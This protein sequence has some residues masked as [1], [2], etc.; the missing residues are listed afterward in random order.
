MKSSL[1]IALASTVALLGCETTITTATSQFHTN[2]PLV[3]ES[4]LS[5]DYWV[6]R[7]AT[8]DAVLKN[9]SE[10]DSF[11]QALIDANPHIEDVFALADT[12]GAE[13]L[14]NAIEE[15][16][17][18]PK[19]AR[20]YANGQQLTD[21]DWQQLEAS[22]NKTAVKQT[23]P[24]KLGL[25]VRRA[26]LRTYPTSTPVYKPDMD[27]DLDRFQET[28]LYP[29]DAVALLHISVDGQWGFV[30]AFHYRAWVPLADIALG[31][32]EKIK[33]F[34]FPAQSLVVTGAQ[35]ETNFVPDT[36]EVSQIT[37]DMGVTLP[38]V[39]KPEPVLYG[40]NTTYSRMVQLPTRAADGSLVIRKALIA[41]SQDTHVGY[42]PF[43]QRNLIT[44]AFKFLGERYGWG[45]GYNARDCTGFVSAIYRSMGM[46]MP[47]NSSQQGSSD[48]GQNWHY[49]RSTPP[50]DEALSE[51][52]VGDLIY[53]PGHVMMLLGQDDSGPFVIH[54]VKGLA[55]EN[56]SGEFYRSTLNGVSVT[57][58]A[59]LRL[60]ATTR[61]IDRIYNIKRIG[62]L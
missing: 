5:P 56:D 22:L 26:L 51:L 13:A 54:D 18:R 59:P 41:R 10:I 50:T 42:L 58:L 47:R 8:P 23:N 46:R 11:N 1:L 25:V 33:A 27:F 30:Q 49:T 9:A 28:A 31:D 52:Q 43:T 48:Y 16:S 17:Q 29:G 53:I 32:K 62:S 38:L 57:P 24:V 44:Q 37:L 12:M 34:T 6:S 60:S 36:P 20:F 7:L 35:V 15:I 45:G 39:N 4:Q 2:V 19:Q 40:Q 55:Y 14:L 3:Q 21:N 61:Y